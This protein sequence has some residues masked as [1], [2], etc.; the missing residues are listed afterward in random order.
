MSKLARLIAAVVAVVA[1]TPGLASAG[2]DPA[3][4]VLTDPLN[5]GG[6]L[7]G[8]YTPPW[9][10]LTAGYISDTADTIS[11]TWEVADLSSHVPAAQA[12]TPYECAD[13]PTGAQRCAL[14][15]G[16]A[17]FFWEFALAPS[18]EE[19]G[20]CTDAAFVS[21]CFSLRASL[22]AAGAAAALTANCTTTGNVVSCRAIPDADITISID[23]NQL[24]ATLNRSDIGSPADGFILYEQDLFQGI[25]AYTGAVLI[26]GNA[27]DLANLDE[28]FYVMGTHR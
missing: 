3:H 21:N 1:L 10:D 8:D 17:H 28:G 2:A 19:T 20:D 25:G 11:F 5:D 16:S 27:G 18:V 24:T 12:G 4:Q 22:D 23:G 26:S 14:R 13:D 7:A 9:Q 15:R 6:L